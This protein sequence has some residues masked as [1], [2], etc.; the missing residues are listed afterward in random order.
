MRPLC[1]KQKNKPK[2]QQT[3]VDKYFGINGVMMYLTPKNIIAII[4]TTIINSVLKET[5]LDPSMLPFFN[6]FYIMATASNI[7]ILFVTIL[8]MSL[9]YPFDTQIHSPVRYH[10]IY[11]CR[12]IV[13]MTCHIC[14]TS[15]SGFPGIKLIWTREY[16]YELEF[17]LIISDH[18]F[19]YL[20]YTP[21]SSYIHDKKK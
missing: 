11:V 17:G 13:Q 8:S 21:C 3:N 18:C 7:V 5:P 10:K 15:W 16:S 14:A 19:L 12:L 9:L 4:R 1:I 2:E 20:K 6:I